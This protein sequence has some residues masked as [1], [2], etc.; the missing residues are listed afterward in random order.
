M[1]VLL[2]GIERCDSITIDAHKW[3][4]T[5]M[6]CSLFLA[7]DPRVLKHAFFVDSYFMP[8]SDQSA[9]PHTTTLQ[10]SRRF[11]GLRLFLSLATVGWQGYGDH[12]E[13]SVDLADLLTRQLLERGW[14]VPNRSRLAVVCAIPPKEYP[15]ARD[16]V[17]AVV[18]SG[19]AWI[20]SS[21]FKGRDVLRICLTNG[22]TMPEDVMA[23]VEL[24]DGF[25]PLDTGRT[26]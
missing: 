4:A 25:R 1:K 13:R 11:L 22:R 12:V 15:A 23:L 26:A 7:R 20:S 21:K 18:A 5:T 14:V 16:I 9:D 2:D 3:L 10:W 17:R 8:P 19:R 6:A 24:L